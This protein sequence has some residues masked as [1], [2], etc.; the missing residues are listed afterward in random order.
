MARVG[1]GENKQLVTVRVIKSKV[2]LHHETRELVVCVKSL[3]A[4]AVVLISHSP[5]K[6][7]FG[8]EVDK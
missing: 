4:S 6:E 2:V 5:T 8:L 1:Y 7:T 3:R